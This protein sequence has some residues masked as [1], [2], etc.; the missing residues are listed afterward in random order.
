MRRSILGPCVLFALAVLL[1]V[2]AYVLNSQQEAP[3]PCSGPYC[4]VTVT[5]NRIGNVTI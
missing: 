1:A 3:L 5:D 2:A 4:H